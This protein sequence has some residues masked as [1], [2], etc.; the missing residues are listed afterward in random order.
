MASI[1]FPLAF[2]RQFSGPLDPDLVFDTETA[3]ADYLTSPRRYAGQVVTCNE[4]PGTLF[5]LNAAA[6]D[7]ISVP[8]IHNAAVFVAKVGD[9][10]NPG[11]S[12]DRPKATIGSAIT[13]ASA[14]ITA[15]AT[16][17]RVHVIDGGTYTEDI[18]VPS[19]VSID[20]KGA[21]LVGAI[22]LTA[23]AEAFFDRHFAA[24]SNQN[25]VT[26]DDAG[27][28]AA[29]YASNFCDGRGTTGTLT[30]VQNV[31]NIGGGGKNLF[32]RVGIMFVG[33]DGVGL[34]NTSSGFGHVHFELEDLYLAGNNAIGINATATG[35]NAADLVGMIHHI[36]E[37][38]SPTGTTGIGINNA[39]AVV[40]IVAAE[41]VADTAYNITAGSLYLVCPKITG[42]QTGTAL[43]LAANDNAVVKL[44]G[45]QTIDGIK[46][47]LQRLVS[48]EL[49]A[50]TDDGLDIAKSD[51]TSLIRV[52]KDGA[53]KTGVAEGVNT[54]ASGLRSH[55]EGQG[56]TAS[57]TASH[58]EGS[59][60]T[61]SGDASHAGGNASLASQTLSYARGRRA[62]SIHAGASVESDNQNADFE[63]TAD[64]QKSFRFAGGYRFFGGAAEFE[65][66]SGT[67]ENLGAAP[68]TPTVNAQTGT[69]YT[70]ALVDAGA[71]VTATNADAVTVTVPTNASVAF[72][73]GTII[74]VIQAGAGVV[75][76]QGDTGVT[77][78]GTS[79]GSVDTTTQYQGAALLKTG[80]DEWIISGAVE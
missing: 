53:S 1:S 28:G 33:A 47:F 6:D 37:T 77:V 10:A 60:T 44:T 19:N 21:T 57:G 5:I 79:G 35:P 9:D 29:I 13:Q 16:G 46:T 8:T 23:G 58:A 38:G 2:Q 73:V 12:I 71:V 41:I 39:A 7:W 17:V 70:L 40:K 80:A 20:A 27:S 22:S 52:G 78:N 67:R 51:G 68:L 76:L 63:S 65:N 72:P 55:A 50:R 25:M 3:L 34:G 61:A 43:F 26:M 48:N 49:R 54:T 66:A 4:L 11:T 75:T 64:N 69:S 36:L 14:L 45:D 24:S 56:T 42:T 30:G 32:V 62:R 59:N 31:R 74:N 15:G 18:T